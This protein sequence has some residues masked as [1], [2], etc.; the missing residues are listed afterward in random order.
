[1][2]LNEL[3][4]EVLSLSEAERRQLINI[5]MQ[6]FPT[7]GKRAAFGCMQGT[8]EILGDIVEPALDESEWEVL[9]EA[10]A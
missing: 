6:S 4:K 3:Q 7:T 8:G 9:R 1:M 5:L 2:T 10:V